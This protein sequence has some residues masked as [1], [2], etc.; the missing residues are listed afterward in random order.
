[1]PSSQQDF[2]SKELNQHPDHSEFPFAQQAMAGSID[3][4]KFTSPYL[5]HALR[6]RYNLA[7]FTD[8]KCC[9]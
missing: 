3:A 6:Q 9:A 7:S 5:S 1:M 4:K 2:S 8:P